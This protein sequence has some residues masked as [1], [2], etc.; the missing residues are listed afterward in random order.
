ME[1]S[2]SQDQGAFP[3]TVMHLQG[4]LDGSN[5]ETLIAEAQKQ[6]DAGVRNLLL[7][8]SQLDFLSSAGLS[9]LHTVALLFRGQK[10]AEREE[11]WAAFRSMDRDRQSGLQEHVKLV[12]PNADVRRILETVGFDAFFQVFNDIH[13]AV[14]SFQ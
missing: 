12:N 6:Y 10:P 9:A 1:I 13:Q 14:G 3:V 11:G 5:Y 2:I 4:K 7:D 8:F